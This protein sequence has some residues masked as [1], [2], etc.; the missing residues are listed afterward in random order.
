ME[1]I[2]V[3]VRSLSF[4]Q[5]EIESPEVCEADPRN[6]ENSSSAAGP[7]FARGLGTLLEQVK[8]GGSLPHIS[9]LGPRQQHGHTAV[10]S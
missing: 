5:Q 6:D 2:Q 4:H 3:D 7:G 9:V 8:T 1:L 10:A